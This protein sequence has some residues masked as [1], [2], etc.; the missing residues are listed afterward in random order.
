MANRVCGNEFICM[1]N[2]HLFRWRWL[3]EDD[4][5]LQLIGCAAPSAGKGEKD[6]GTN[7]S[8][9]SRVFASSFR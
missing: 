6:A 5:T 9:G 4:V 2:F 8:G 1:E 7:L 3:P